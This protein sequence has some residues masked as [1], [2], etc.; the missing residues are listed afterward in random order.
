MVCYRGSSEMDVCALRSVDL[1]PLMILVLKQSAELGEK[2]M[3]V[4]L[5]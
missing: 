3:K 1:T 5:I 2:N 4:V